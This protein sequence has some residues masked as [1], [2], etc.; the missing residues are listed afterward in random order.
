MKISGLGVF[1]LSEKLKIQ[2]VAAFICIDIRAFD[3][4]ILKYFIILTEY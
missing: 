1:D 4:A 2:A 3:R